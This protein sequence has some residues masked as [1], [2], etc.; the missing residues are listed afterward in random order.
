MRGGVRRRAVARRLHRLPSGLAAHRPRLLRRQV[1]SQQAVVNNQ[2]TTTGLLAITT[3]FNVL[4]TLIATPPR[5]LPCI[6]VF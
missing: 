4:L 1:L 2:L 3:P 5:P 6:A